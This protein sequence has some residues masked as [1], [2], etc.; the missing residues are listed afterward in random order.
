MLA[1]SFLMGSYT[2]SSSLWYLNLNKSVL[3]PPGYVFGIVWSLLYVAIAI[4]GWLIFVYYVTTKSIKTAYILQLLFNW[5]WTPLFFVFHL[6][7]LSLLI[8]LLLII[9][10][11]Y[12]ILA[13]DRMLIKQLL[14]PYLL[15]LMF[16][17]YL[18][19]YILITN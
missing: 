6:I 15:W 4:V 17:G 16:A 18:N 14:L 7:S 5:S 3:T 12:I 8:I 13:E 1:L 11:F 2:S 10:V 19:F 9:I